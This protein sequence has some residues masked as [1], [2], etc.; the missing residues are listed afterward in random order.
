MVHHQEKQAGPA[1][2]VGGW[3]GGAEGKHMI[4]YS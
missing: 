2:D 4:R 3:K 1:A